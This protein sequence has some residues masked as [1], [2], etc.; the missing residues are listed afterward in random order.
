[1]STSELL[2][3]GA[4]GF[5]GFGILKAISARGGTA[6]GLVR[7][8]RFGPPL[9]G[10]S[11]RSVEDYREQALGNVLQGVGAV[12]HAA[13]VVHR[14]D[15]PREAYESFNR[16]GTRAL[17]A[18]CRAQGVARLVFLSTIKVYGETPAGIMDESTPVMPEG[19]Y[20]QTKLTA[21]RIV[22]EAAESGGPSAAI[23]RLCPVY[24]RGDKGN[25]R[26]MIRAIARR[27]FV[28]PGR[29]A[30]RKSLVHL[31]TVA[32]VAIAGAGATAGGVFVVA[33]RE[34]PSMSELSDAIARALD[35][36]RP[37]R[38]PVAIVHAA[39]AAA[40]LAAQVT[41]RTPP[42]TR[43]LLRKSLQPSVC[44][45]KR[46]EEQLGVSC[47]VDL[48]EAIRDEVAWMREERLL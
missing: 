19:G 10:V 1:M 37:L 35:R 8:G 36:P 43:D 21:E 39:A 11:W 22:L 14:P 13:S 33:D 17:V 3:T 48:G 32:N 28:L 27:R 38:V 44:S 25:V 46:V 9:P 42:V 41:R 18:A 7:E 15:A 24:G 2:V 16:D 12:I 23:L 26:T 34:A 5:V 4:S 29:G 40:E 30:T 31:S 20:A 47:H 6:I 45:P